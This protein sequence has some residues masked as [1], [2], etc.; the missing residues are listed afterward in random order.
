MIRFGVT[1]M[2]LA[3]AL[4]ACGE[5]IQTTTASEKKADA[6]SWQA[7]NSVFLAPGWTPSDKVAWEAQLRTRAQAQ[8]DFALPPTK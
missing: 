7:N 8:N 5:R 4:S 3:S 1:C 6:P 2:L